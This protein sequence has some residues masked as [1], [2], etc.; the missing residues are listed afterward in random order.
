M[1]RRGL[2]FWYRLG[3]VLAR[4]FIPT[5]GS[6]EV[7]GRENVPPYGPLII[8][9]NHQSYADPP[10]LVYA[11]ERPL[12]WMAKR[13]LFS[14]LLNAYFMRA[15]HV[16]P[17]D[18]DARDLGALR[19]AQETLAA[20]RALVLF[21]E[22]TRSPGALSEASDGLTYLALRSGAPILP[23]A[24]TGTERVRGMAKIAFHFQ[25]LRVVIGEPFTLPVVEGR[26]G[27]EVL[28]YPTDQVMERI[29]A[30]L[31]PEYRGVYAGR[32][33]EPERG[34]SVS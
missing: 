24:I 17:I 12:W 27:R 26:I 6:I 33:A 21:P 19:W 13:A 32:P 23:V 29:A 5:F 31:P 10:V 14:N 2:D 9:P 1:R 4:I 11:I 15:A 8:A 22:G 34:E 3:H 30:L 20:D 25:R 16:H 7:V 28:H 18:R